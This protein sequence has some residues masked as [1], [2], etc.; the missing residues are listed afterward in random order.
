MVIKYLF[1]S[2]YFRKF[3]LTFILLNL[4]KKENH[5]VTMALKSYNKIIEPTP[6]SQVLWKSLKLKV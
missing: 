6:K 5:N 4:Q 1:A 2:D 3:I